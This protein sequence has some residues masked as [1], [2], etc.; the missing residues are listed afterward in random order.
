LNLTKNNQQKKLFSNCSMF[1]SPAAKKARLNLSDIMYRQ[2]L[3]NENAE[4]NGLNMDVD[5]KDTTKI[6][7][8]LYSR[9]IY[10]LG[11]E[12][13]SKMANSSILIIGLDGL[14]VE[15][16]KNIIL[17]GVRRVSLYDPRQPTN[18]DL[19]SHYY[20]RENEISLKNQ[21]LA[22]LS[23]LRLA[24]L[25]SYVEVDVMEYT[26]NGHATTT[27][28]TSGGDDHYSYIPLPNHD[29]ISGYKV[30]VLCNQGCSR[31]DLIEWT[32]ELRKLYVDTKLLI[33]NSRGLFGQIFVDFGNEFI[34]QD[35]TGEEPLSV[36]LQDIENSKEGVVTCLEETRHGFEDGDFVTFREVSGMSEINDAQPKQVK[37]LGPVAFSIGDTTNYGRYSGGG[38]CTQVKMPKTIKFL[39]L[40]EALKQ[41]DYL[42]SDFAK[43]DYPTQSHALFQAL[44]LYFIKTNSF[45]R[46]WHKD[47]A[48]K[49]LKFVDELLLNNENALN[50]GIENG[51][52]L[53]KRLASLFAFTAC[54]NLAPMQAVLGGITAQE[55]MKACSHRFMPI[56]QWFYFDC[57]EILPMNAVD[58]DETSG[59][60]RSAIFTTEDC[61]INDKTD[62]SFTRYAGQIAVLSKEFQEKLVSLK[63][64]IVGA[65][66]IG[67]E[68]LKNFSLMGVGCSSKGKIIVT[69]MDQIE[70][71]NLNRQFLFRSSDIG[72]LKSVAASKAVKQMNPQ[73]NIQSHE[74]RVGPETENIYTDDF[75]ES[76][77]GVAN[78]LD[79]VEARAY[80]DRRCV[81]YCKPLLESGTLGTKGN[82]QVIVP[83]LTESYTSSQDPPEKSIPMC[84]LK[85]F[86]YAIEHTLQWARDTFEGIFCEPSQAALAYLRDSETC[87]SKALALPGRQPQ[88]ALTTLL[89]A[90]V[91]QRPNSFIDCVQWARELFEEYFSNQIKQLLHNF[92]ANQKTENGAPFWSGTKRCPKPLLFKSDNETHLEFIFSAANVRACVYG[93]EQCRDYKKVKELVGQCVV[94][95]FQPRD[96]IKIAITEADAENNRTSGNPTGVYDPSDDSNLTRLRDQLPNVASLSH[97]QIQPMEFEKDDDENLH[98]DFITS[99]SNLRAE[100]YS[101]PPADKLKSKLIAGKIIP[102]I[103]TTTSIVAGLVSIELYKLAQGHKKLEMF[104]NGFLNLALPFFAFSEPIPPSKSKYYEKEFTLWDRFELKDELTLG[105]MMEYFQNEHKLN[106]SMISQGVCMLYSFFLPAATQKQRME[107]TLRNIV[108]TV[109]KKPIPKHVKSLVF[110]L[111]CSDEND[112]DVEVPYVKYTLPTSS[113]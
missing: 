8:N 34:V 69:D 27:S 47:D 40:K 85:N 72:Q 87:L 24:E 25:N 14:G 64:F 75:F 23:R 103:A 57:E 59:L 106:I 97:L 81:F 26:N 5:K 28:R 51:T 76:L 73:L 13:M 39:G 102:A 18:W 17:G 11:K 94:K 104:K 48:Q 21:T 38:I 32:N 95:P 9:Q 33:V 29:L 16:A 55:V 61:I 46:P 49:F 3:R 63:Y 58:V 60:I 91:T 110:E 1:K 65:G 107:M 82:V 53:N 15:V 71:S 20:I 44:D 35:T 112:E 100:N 45:P 66:A 96:G 101:I 89:Q 108:E 68:L 22:Q 37:V 98:M 10:V 80:M 41:P 109:S 70:R 111:C 2:Q 77:D 90:L 74:L 42:I 30:I 43:F 6:D 7:E 4:T 88:E 19:A 86:P 62:K 93:I 50:M 56:H 92:P 52:I 105:Q 78:A 113:S 54:G 12:A 36:M 99:C 83:H 79:N 84:T 67:C 31:P